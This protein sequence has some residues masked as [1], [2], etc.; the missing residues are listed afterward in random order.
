MWQQL[1]ASAAL[2]IEWMK[3]VVR[4]GWTGSA[5]RNDARPKKTRAERIV[6]SFMRS[7]L[8]NG[9]LNPYG[10]KAVELGIGGMRPGEAL[11]PV[12]PG[13]PPPSRGDPGP[14]VPF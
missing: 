14:D 3:I 13:Q 10:P 12:P 11:P 8:V 6:T 4:H 9:L 2:L 5:R 1:R 7:R